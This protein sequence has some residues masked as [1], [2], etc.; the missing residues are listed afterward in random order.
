MIILFPKR[1]GAKIATTILFQYLRNGAGFHYCLGAIDFAFA[2][3]A[4]TE[5]EK[6][7]LLE[8]LEERMRDRV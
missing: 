1:K 6:K 2:F 8:Y 5:K 3:G 4:I 7:A